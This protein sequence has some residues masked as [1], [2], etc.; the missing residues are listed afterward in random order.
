MWLRYV[1][2]VQLMKS[3]NEVRTAIT[4]AKIPIALT[5]VQ[6]SEEKTQSCDIAF[7]V[8]HLHWTTVTAGGFHVPSPGGRI[9]GGSVFGQ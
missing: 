5:D 1:D 3:G 7:L 6:K 8:I 9:D 2:E 4:A